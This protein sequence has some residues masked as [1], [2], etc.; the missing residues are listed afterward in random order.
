MCRVHDLVGSPGWVKSEPQRHV[1]F[2]T[3][4]GGQAEAIFM[5]ADLRSPISAAEG[6]AAVAGWWK[7]GPGIAKTRLSA[8]PDVRSGVGGEADLDW[9]EA[10]MTGVDG[11]LLQRGWC[12]GS[13]AA[14]QAR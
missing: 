4:F 13:R 6:I 2:T 11:L 12:T 8:F 10:A 9:A 3:A 7:A 1:Q 14:S 5:K